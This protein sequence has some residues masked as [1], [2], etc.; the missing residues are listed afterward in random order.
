LGVV[1]ETWWNKSEMGMSMKAENG[2]DI[3]HCG[4]GLE[5]KLDK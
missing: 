1:V 4:E 5:A 3:S 2:Q